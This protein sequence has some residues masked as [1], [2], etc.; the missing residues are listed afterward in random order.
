VTKRGDHR[1]KKKRPTM[2]DQGISDRISQ[3]KATAGIR[4]D[5]AEE[6]K[7]GKGRKLLYAL[8]G[9]PLGGASN[10]TCDVEYNL[11]ENSLRQGGAQAKRGRT[12]QA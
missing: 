2:L 7:R 10:T 5:L 6:E 1:H 8:N 4:G 11:P 3:K 9:G 12:T